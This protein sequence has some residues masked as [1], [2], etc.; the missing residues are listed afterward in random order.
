[1]KRLMLLCLLTFGFIQAALAQ[2]SIQTNT[3][4]ICTLQSGELQ[5]CVNEVVSSTLTLNEN[6]FKAIQMLNGSE[7]IYAIESKVYENP[8][9]KYT[10]S[11]S[12]GD[13]MFL[14]VHQSIK[15]F[16]FYPINGENGATVTIYKFN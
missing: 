12:Q 15:E 4:S 5:G 13:M 9:W 7:V 14:K 10:I 1:M 3:K 11:N 2:Q 16:G 8:Y 6:M